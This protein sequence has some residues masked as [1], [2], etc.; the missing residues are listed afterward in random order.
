MKCVY[1][2]EI[3]SVFTA[4]SLKQSIQMNLTIIWSY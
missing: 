4:I 3:C 2:E 1:N